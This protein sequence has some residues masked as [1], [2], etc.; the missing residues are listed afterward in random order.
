M[1]EVTVSQLA[2][3]IGIPADRLMEQLANAGIRAKHP[4]DKISDDE[5]ARLL[6]HLRQSHG[7]QQGTNAAA[8]KKVTLRRKTV[9]ELR[10][11]TASGRTTMSR[12]SPSAPAKT[13]SVEVRKKRTYVK[14][15]TIVKDE[16]TLREAEAARKALEEQ[17]RQKAA[18]EAEAEARKQAERAKREAQEASARKAEEE[19]RAKEA[20]EEAK[21]KAEEEGTGAAGKI[22]EEGTGVGARQEGGAQGTGDRSGHRRRGNPLSPQGTA[23][24]RGKTRLAQE[25]TQSSSG[26]QADPGRPARF[27]ETYSPSGA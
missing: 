16:T 9:S 26:H 18:I 12:T 11:P 7:K 23:R 3:V 13:V 19:A 10:Q 22:G 14:R 4:D 2:K 27:S 1:S 24:G 17:A 8:P 21:R 5:K 20:E 25:E 15:A 6:S